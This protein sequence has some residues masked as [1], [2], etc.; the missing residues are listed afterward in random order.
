MST[1]LLLSLMRLALVVLHQEMA[2]GNQMLKP[3]M[4]SLVRE[5][6]LL[7]TSL[8]V[9]NSLLLVTIWIWLVS[10]LLLIQFKTRIWLIMLTELAH[11][12]TM[13]FRETLNQPRLLVLVFQVTLLGSIPP[14]TRMLSAFS[15]TCALRVSSYVSMAC[16]VFSQSLL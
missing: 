10:R 14:L 4:L 2:S 6:R 1:K 5:L 7:V 3:I 11:L 16:A 9:I 13:I 12:L 15:S 8:K